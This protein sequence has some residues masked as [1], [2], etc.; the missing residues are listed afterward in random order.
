MVFK[1]VEKRSTQRLIA[2]E[3][4]PGRFIFLT[5]VG[6]REKNECKR[7]W[8]FKVRGSFLNKTGDFFF[9]GKYIK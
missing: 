6:F 9:S 4:L 3:I 1:R 5:P 2:Y 7:D 8:I